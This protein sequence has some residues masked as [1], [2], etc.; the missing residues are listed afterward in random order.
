MSI[1]KLVCLGDGYGHWFRAN[2]FQ[3]Y[4]LFF[5]FYRENNIIFLASVNDK[6][7]KRACKSNTNTY[8]IFRKTLESGHPA[9]KWDDLLIGAKNVVKRSQKVAETGL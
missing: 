5:R 7:S 1:N 2:F 3:R 8:K 9:D 6:N 4:R